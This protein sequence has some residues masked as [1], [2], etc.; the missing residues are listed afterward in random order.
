MSHMHS[1]GVWRRKVGPARRCRLWTGIRFVVTRTQLSA[2]ARHV[3]MDHNTQPGHGEKKGWIYIEK[4]NSVFFEGLVTKTNPRYDRWWKGTTL[5]S[6]FQRRG[7][8]L[9]HAWSNVTYLPTRSLVHELPPT[10]FVIRY[11]GQITLNKNPF[12]HSMILYT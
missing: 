6:R 7:N 11:I 5:L 9:T 2:L 1:V 12:L 3:S 8:K 10:I 4:I